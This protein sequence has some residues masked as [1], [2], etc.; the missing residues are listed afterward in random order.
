MALFASRDAL[1]GFSPSQVDSEAAW[2]ND[3][4]EFLSGVST[5]NRMI[6]VDPGFRDMLLAQM[7]KAAPAVATA[8]NEEFLPVARRAFNEWPV[9]TGFSKSQLDLSVG[10]RGDGKAI[11]V[12]LVNNAPYA[13]L[14]NRGDTAEKLIFQAGEEAADRM[15]QVI[16]R[17]LE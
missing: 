12:S 6:N 5:G 13:G 11:T 4:A 2:E 15:A 17:E 8:I 14:I 9:R 3:G 7:A 16:L 10:V 1:V